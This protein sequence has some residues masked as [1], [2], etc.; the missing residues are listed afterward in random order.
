MAIDGETFEYYRITK[1]VKAIKNSIDILKKHGYV[2]I[3]LEGNI[4]RKEL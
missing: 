4:L 1:K 3:D 2:I